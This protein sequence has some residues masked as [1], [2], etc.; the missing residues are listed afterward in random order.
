MTHKPEWRYIWNESYEYR[1]FL[2]TLSRAT[3]KISQCCAVQSSNTSW[4]RLIGIRKTPFDPLIF[5]IGLL[6][7][8]RG[9]SSIIARTTSRT[10][11]LSDTQLLMVET[12]TPD[13]LAPIGHPSFI[14]SYSPVPRSF[15]ALLRGILRRVRSLS[16]L[17]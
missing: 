13:V 17:P 7:H 14:S 1:A 9:H 2:A 15:G 4:R 6:F 5:S 16:F 8:S 10:D 11:V 3:S 12:T